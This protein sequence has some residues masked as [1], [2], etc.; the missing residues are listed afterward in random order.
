M[1]NIRISI[2]GYRDFIDL[3]KGIIQ[4]NKYHASISIY[5]CFLH[6]CL[7]ILAHLEETQTDVII[8]GRANKTFL[9]NRTKIPILTFRITPFDMLAAVKKALRHSN[10]IAIALANFEHLE[11]D[12]TILE[13]F[14]NIKLTFISYNTEDD[15]RDKIRQFSHTDG[16]VIGTSIAVSIAKDLGL[17]GIL[18]YTLENSI[19]ESIER[20]IE[21]VRFKE[22]EE[23]NSKQFKAIMD[24][25][26]DGIIATNE[27]NEI[28]LINEPSWELLQIPQHDHPAPRLT[29]IFNERLVAEFSSH[30]NFQDKIIKAGNKTLNLNRISVFVRG[31]QAGNV[32]TLQDITQIQKI[33]QKYRM[34]TEAKGLVAKTKFEDI[35]CSNQAMRKTIEKAKK[36]AQTESTIL[37]MGETGTGKELFAQSI[38]NQ[39]KRHGYPFVAINC[40]ALPESL[41]ESELFGYEDGAFTGASKNGKKGLFEIAHNGTI[42]LDEINSITLHSQARLLRVLQEREV[43]RIGSDKV[44]PINVRI[45]AASNEDLVSLIKEN[46]FR[47]DLYYRLNV[48]NLVL[49]PLRER[50]NDILPLAKQFIYT[51]NREWYKKLDPYLPEICKE[52]SGYPFPGNVRQLHNILERFLV[53]LE[54]ESSL[55]L[56][57]IKSLL[58][59]CI[60]DQYSE[61]SELVTFPIKESYKDSLFEAEKSLMLK[62]LEMSNG[63][64]SSLAEKLSIGKTTLYRKLKEL[65]ISG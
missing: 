38:H 44:I 52:L 18:I 42:F 60:D 35:V 23:K 50:M 4:N 3:T 59:E 12:Y 9:E 17:P 16:V 58:R 33:E 30:D 46:K 2:L 13:E 32:I 25:V 36:F 1:E 48:L 31:K 57:Q 62:Y 47:A 6:D 26:K 27:K 40:G 37:I 34:E 29:D 63:D 20:A 11:Y 41:L 15:L 8:T 28:T 56:Q 14:L 55:N 7:P 22:A 21:L 54:M 10:S 51:Q 61:I 49:P 24:S 19:N 64:K 43:S 5:Q 45:I 53:L 39:S 65:N